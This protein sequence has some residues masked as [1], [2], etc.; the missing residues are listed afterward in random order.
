MAYSALKQRYRKVPGVDRKHVKSLYLKGSLEL[1]SQ[2]I[3]KRHHPYMAVTLLQSRPDTLAEPK[4]GLWVERSATR[5][6]I[7]RTMVEALNPK[8]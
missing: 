8:A 4:D 2:R 5:E 1:L 6:S 7:V 3:Q